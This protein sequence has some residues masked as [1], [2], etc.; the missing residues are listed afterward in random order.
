MLTMHNAPAKLSA[1][2]ISRQASSQDTNGRGDFLIPADNRIQPSSA[3]RGRYMVVAQARVS[4]VVGVK[5][6]AA[7]M[8]RPLCAFFWRWLATV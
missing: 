1:T 7:T 6:L 2:K 8:Y 4:P 3:Q 5:C